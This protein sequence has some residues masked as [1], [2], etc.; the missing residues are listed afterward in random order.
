M[1]R[2]PKS[3]PGAGAA[4]A[5]VDLWE[6]ESD[7]RKLFELSSEARLVLDADGVVDC[8][9][10]ALDLFDCADLEQMRAL[11]VVGLSSRLQ[12]DGRLSSDKVVSILRRCWR[13]GSCRVDWRHR[14][15]DGIE[16]PAE[17]RLDRFEHRGRTLLQAVVRDVSW[18]WEAERKLRE[19]EQRFRTLVENQGEGIGTVDLDE[20]FEFANPAAEAIFGVEP[21]G[22]EGRGL[23]E[24]LDPE[25]LAAVRAQTA[26]RRS[27]ERDA[28]QL[29]VR[30]ADGERRWLNVT[31]VPRRDAAGRRIVGAFGIFRDVT[32]QHR[33]EE[34]LR[35]AKEETE[36]ANARLERA[37]ARAERL[38][39]AA[40][41]ASRAKG[42]FLANM[43][44]EIRTPMNGIIGMIAMLLDSPLTEEQRDFAATARSSA[45]HL[46][47]LIDDILDFSKIESGKL[48]I[49]HI[50]FDLHQT[51]EELNKLLG[52][53]ARQRGI[54]YSCRI[55]PEVP[56]RLRGDP[57]RL[58]QVLTNLVGNA[59]KFT[60]AGEVS[61]RVELVAATGPGVRLRFAV[62][63]TGIGIPA[64]AQRAIFEPFEQADGST[65]R[66]HGGTGLGLAISRE[67]VQRM[68]GRVTLD[69]QPG[70]GSTFSFEVDCGQAGGPPPPAA[71][72]AR[73]AAAA[74]RPARI[75]VAE[76][77]PTNQKVAAA[78]LARAGHRADVV[79]DG[80]A[81]LA[82][83]REV[84]YDLVLMDV[85]MP[86]LDGFEATRRIRAGEAGDERRA[87]PVIAMTGHAMEG[88]RDRC[89]AAGMNDY[90]AKPVQPADLQAVVAHWLERDGAEA[91]APSP[92]AAAPEATATGAA[93]AGAEEA[94]A[95]DAEGLVARLLGDRE[96]AADILSGFLDDA[97]RQLSA[98]RRAAADADRAAVGRLAHTLKGAAA[99]ACAAA[100]AARVEQLEAATADPAAALAPRLDA[101]DAALAELR[102]A[103]EGS[104]LIGGEP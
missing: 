84:D 64:A 1:E 61:I 75:L 21:G 6:A 74:V 88:D 28:Y 42:Q 51:L 23:D 63:D 40:E 50:D 7:F 11:G 27:G 66:I 10:T 81:T 99:N 95:L 16:F 67:L 49:E 103:A 76:D 3:R 39:A 5:G 45:E 20:R 18:Q 104:G 30:R 79:V 82:A 8:N 33:A 4:D 46:L 70:R 100:L 97:A 43:S 98:M 53:R 26:R 15:A 91:A 25:Q 48:A 90:I 29:Q 62:R 31:A 9:Q 72:P 44:H 47:T 24:F 22:L 77:D 93:G 41:Q 60:E 78:V 71:K 85:Q 58:R 12:P 55:A 13:Q 65:T 96:L 57:G 59:I 2:G 86:V 17:V 35:R 69:S 89:L 14:R 83:L 32:A 80:E 34:A 94:A 101:L 73:P 37:I 19:S 56:R 92:S 54:G 36:A 68:G 87:V 52:P 102:R 38:A